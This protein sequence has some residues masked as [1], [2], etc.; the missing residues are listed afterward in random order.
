[1]AVYLCRF[2]YVLLI[3]L[4]FEV[5][6]GVRLP[7]IPDDAFNL[8]GLAMPPD[9]PAVF[10]TPLKL[11]NITSIPVNHTKWGGAI[12]EAFDGVSKAEANVALAAHER[13]SVAAVVKSTQ[14]ILKKRLRAAN[15][16]SVEGLEE[17]LATDDDTSGLKQKLVFSQ[18]SHDK[19]AQTLLQMRRAAQKEREAA[20]AEANAKNSAEDAKQHARVVCQNAML[21]IGSRLTSTSSEIQREEF[22]IARTRKLIIS[23][24]DASAKVPDLTG[25]VCVLWNVENQI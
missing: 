23:K 21:G 16:K 3:G 5:V 10:H 2:G 17:A 8:D 4:Y 6:C 11:L 22:R 15:A 12:I 7:Y 20:T 9:P 24:L 19:A 14:K 1:M 13:K 25:F 18:T